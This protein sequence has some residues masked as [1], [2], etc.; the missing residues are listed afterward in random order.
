MIRGSPAPGTRCVGVS[1]LA[2]TAAACGGQQR[3]PSSG[4]SGGGTSPDSEHAG[5]RQRGQG[6]H[7]RPRGQLGERVHLAGPEPLQPAAAAQRDRHRAAARPGHVAGTSRT[8]GLDLHVPPAARAKFSDG[9]PVTAGDVVYSIER[10]RNSKG[11]WGFLLTAGQDDH[12]PG[13]AHGRDHA[14]AAARAAAGRPGHVRLLGGPGEAGQGAGQRRSSSTRSAAGRSWSPPT[15][16]TARSTWPATRTSTGPS[17]RSPSRQD[18]DRAQRQHPGADAG[19]QEGRHHREPAGQPGQR[20]QQDPG[21]E[22][23]ALPLH[24]GRLHPAR[25]A[26]RPVQEPVRSGRR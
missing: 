25:R 23:A 9:T 8:S 22:R 17:P 21:P 11:G 20:D 7:A 16:P 3:A 15:A 2:L 12:R 18:P 13:P 6:R 4:S 5:D 26:L 19:E 14:V 24:P 1:A 10:S